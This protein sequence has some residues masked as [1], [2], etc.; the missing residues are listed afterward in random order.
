MSADE[1]INDTKRALTF[2]ADA[3]ATG[4]VLP[5]AAVDD[6][7]NM[8][9]RMTAHAELL[10]LQ[11]VILRNGYALRLTQVQTLVMEGTDPETPGMTPA[12]RPDLFMQKRLYEVFPLNGDSLTMEVQFPQAVVAMGEELIRG[13]V[14]G[15]VDVD[16]LQYAV[17]RQE[18]READAPPQ[19]PLVIV[20]HASPPGSEP[21]RVY[22]SAPGAVI[23]SV[24]D[25][26]PDD[27]VLR[28]GNNPIPAELLQSM[29]GEPVRMVGDDPEKDAKARQ[30]LTIMK[31]KM[32]LSVV[33]GGK[34]GGETND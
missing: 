12:E 20:H 16:M 32:P 33:A 5:K 19:P 8:L 14:V 10:S 28:M 1:L 31:G 26:A 7:L 2:Y 13:Q 25:N 34:Q 3:K 18:N 15:R 9:Q 23:L 21:V 17:R 29:Q 30:A 6:L 24:D 11:Q 27:R 4:K 22:C